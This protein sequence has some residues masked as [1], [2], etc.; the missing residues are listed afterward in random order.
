LVVPLGTRVCPECGYEFP[1]EQSGKEPGELIEIMPHRE[2]LSWWSGAL[3]R[4]FEDDV[5]YQVRFGELLRTYFYPSRLDTS[6]ATLAIRPGEH[7]IT[8]AALDK[9]QPFLESRL[10]QSVLELGKPP[11]SLQIE[12]SCIHSFAS[13]APPAV[14][15]FSD[16]PQL[17]A[18]CYS[19]IWKY[20]VLQHS[21]FCKIDE[22]IH[23]N[24]VRELTPK[25]ICPDLRL[26]G[27]QA[28]TSKTFEQLQLLLTE[29]TQTCHVTTPLAIAFRA[30]LQN[31][32][33]SP[34]AIRI[35]PPTTNRLKYL[36]ELLWLQKIGSLF[37]P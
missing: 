1:F 33:G 9:L 30:P 31:F 11:Q 2:V 27:I 4:F 12:S 22:V 14:I 13:F 21:T 29:K 5:F 26:I 32:P 23:Q 35:I 28:R 15:E 25:Y 18:E 20:W 34:T 24:F 17:I 3:Q 16:L 8:Y 10:I 37:W 6:C 36:E 7:S 19:N